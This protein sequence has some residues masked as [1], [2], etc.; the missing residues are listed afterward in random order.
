MTPGNAGASGICQGPFNLARQV[1]AGGGVIRGDADADGVGGDGVGQLIARG[2]G[3]TKPFLQ[4][5]DQIE[6]VL[7]G[8]SSTR[9]A[10]CRAAAGPP[11]A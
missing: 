8:G 10:P 6:G 5:F 11:G 4:P 7:V 2:L 3:A 1:I 9:I